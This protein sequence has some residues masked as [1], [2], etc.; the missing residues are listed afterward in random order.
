[1]ENRPRENR[2]Q[3]QGAIGNLQSRLM[4]VTKD[5]KF[6]KWLFRAT[7]SLNGGIPLPWGTVLLWGRADLGEGC[8]GVP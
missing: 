2:F 1:M 8:S 4:D 7:S 5:P 6:G 3:N